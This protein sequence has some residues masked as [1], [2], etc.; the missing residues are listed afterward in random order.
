MLAAL[1]AT[2]I[3]AGVAAVYVIAPWED[4]VESEVVSCE[5]LADSLENI[6]AAGRYERFTNPDGI[7]DY[8]VTFKSTQEA[9]HNN[10]CID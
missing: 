5:E 7:R 9:M 4:G 10:G 8:T 2:F 1:V 6:V 3:I